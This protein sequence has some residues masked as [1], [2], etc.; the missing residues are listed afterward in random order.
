MCPRLDRR[1]KAFLP[2]TAAGTPPDATREDIDTDRGPSCSL[3]AGPQMRSRLA[4]HA[5]QSSDLGCQQAVTESGQLVVAA[6]GILGKGLLARL[7]DD[8]LLQQFF[9]IVVQRSGPQFILPRGLPR[10][11]QHDPVAVQ[12]LTR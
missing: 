10:H 5:F 8:A 7:L 4:Y 6:P 2:R 11:F 1:S 12:I 3:R 9:Q